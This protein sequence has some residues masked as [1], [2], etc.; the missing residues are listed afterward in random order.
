MK[1]FRAWLV[2]NLRTRSLV[3]LKLEMIL[4]LGDL[5]Q[6]DADDNAQIYTYVGKDLYLPIKQKTPRVKI[7]GLESLSEFLL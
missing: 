7:T 5:V 2:R 6:V 4:Q 3:K 1:T